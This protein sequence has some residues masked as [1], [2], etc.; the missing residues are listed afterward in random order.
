MKCVLLFHLIC[1]FVSFNAVTCQWVVYIVWC[2]EAKQERASIPLHYL[3]V[4]FTTITTH[5][6]LLFF[7]LSLMFNCNGTE[8]TVVKARIKLSE[9]KKR[10]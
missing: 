7:F 6:S 9:R 3:F 1:S 8:G 5:S 4:S 10:T 2:S